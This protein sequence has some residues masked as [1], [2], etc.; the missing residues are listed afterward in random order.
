[1]HSGQVQAVSSVTATPFEKKRLIGV[2][3]YGKIDILSD[4]ISME[5][6]TATESL[7]YQKIVFS[8][9]VADAELASVIFIPK[10]D[11]ELILLEEDDENAEE[12]ETL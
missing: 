1:M 7:P 12:Q 8:D 4:T 9:D 3:G 6:V 2:D 10:T 11:A 5:T